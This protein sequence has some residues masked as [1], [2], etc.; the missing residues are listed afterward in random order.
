MGKLWSYL[1]CSKCICS[2]SSSH[3]FRPAAD[4]A[5]AVL[6]RLLA[7]ISE[8]TAQLSVSMERS[9]QLLTRQLQ[10]AQPA[11][12]PPPL[13]SVHHAMA[14]HSTTSS[15][16]CVRGVPSG[17]ESSLPAA[18]MMEQAGPVASLCAGG[19]LPGV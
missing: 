3:L 4:S 10:A 12:T 7:G 19:L 13:H 15:A 1:A 9:K 2:I 5:A 14:G 18:L 6:C 16:Y 17:P 11:V 8:R